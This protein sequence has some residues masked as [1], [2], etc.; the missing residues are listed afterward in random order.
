MCDVGDV[1]SRDGGT[2][3]DGGDVEE[4]RERRQHLKADQGKILLHCWMRGVHRKS[5]H[6]IVTMTS[7]STFLTQ[8]SGDILAAYD[9]IRLKRDMLYTKSNTCYS[10]FHIPYLVGSSLYFSLCSF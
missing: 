10:A 8:W 1:G 9:G 7:L 4:K 5:V 6:W 2:H 3:E